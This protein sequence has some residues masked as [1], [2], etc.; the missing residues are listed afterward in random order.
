LA[1]AIAL[2][3]F[4]LILLIL[5]LD[6]FDRGQDICL[7]TKL[8]GYH[9]W[10]CGMTRACMHLIHL[11]WRQ[12]EQY[13]SKCFIVLPIL[14]GLLVVDFRKAILKYRAIKKV[15]NELQETTTE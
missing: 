14:S 5:P 1:K 12:A 13:N 8:S 4:P 7:F 11:D 3:I 6:F 9:C 15:E 2:A 10:G